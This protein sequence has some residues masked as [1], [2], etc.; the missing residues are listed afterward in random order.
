M[1][2]ARLTLLLL[3]LLPAC[4]LA[5]SSAPIAAAPRLPESLRPDSSARPRLNLRQDVTIVGGGLEVCRTLSN[6]TEA[7]VTIPPL[8]S[9]GTGY[10]QFSTFLF[11][12]GGTLRSWR[13]DELTIMHGMWIP[14]PPPPGPNE[15]QPTLT[16]GPG[17]SFRNCEMYPIPP[18]RSYS[19][20][21]KFSPLRWIVEQVG[22]DPAGTEV[23]SNSCYVR[24]ARIE[25]D[26]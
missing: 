4:E 23:M 10:E 15:P 13:G 6:V 2:R 1:R 17:E 7:P 24:A 16:L 5:R 18:L 26:R 25:C 12:E 20:V 3:T 19:V 9:T 8:T 22:A 21:S 11:E 14:P